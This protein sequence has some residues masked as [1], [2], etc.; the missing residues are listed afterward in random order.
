MEGKG[1]EVPTVATNVTK[2]KNKQKN[3]KKETKRAMKGHEESQDKTVKGNTRTTRQR[4]NSSGSTTEVDPSSIR[5]YF[6]SAKA[7]R[8]KRQREIGSLSSESG[9]S[10][11][12]KKRADDQEDIQQ[13]PGQQQSLQVSTKAEAMPEMASRPP[14]GEH[15]VTGGALRKPQATSEEQSAHPVNSGGPCP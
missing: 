2:K 14:A 15:G 1:D 6:Q 7:I 12:V 13:T 9:T 11:P 8:A 3:R 5:S 10:P 4:P